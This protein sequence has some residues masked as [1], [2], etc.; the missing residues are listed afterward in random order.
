M[1]I[2]DCKH[3]SYEINPTSWFIN[4]CDANVIMGEFEKRM[5]KEVGHC[6]VVSTNLVISEYI[7]PIPPYM[8][9]GGIMAVLAMKYAYP[10]YGRVDLSQVGE[11]MAPYIQEVVKDKN[12]EVTCDIC[13]PYFTEGYCGELMVKNSGKI[14]ISNLE[15][16]LEMM[17]VLEDER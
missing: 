7:G 12:I 5:F 1:L 13:Y 17:R 11:N 3:Y 10:E 16:Y 8:A 15:F 2:V 14:C 9:G 4:A 6:D